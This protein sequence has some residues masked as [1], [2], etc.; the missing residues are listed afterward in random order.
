MIFQT[1]VRV[2]IHEFLKERGISQSRIA[3][4]LDIERSTLHN[5]LK[6]RRPLSPER[7]KE[8][9]DFLNTDFKLNENSL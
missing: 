2:E 3:A 9:N 7:L 5:I 4:L 8:I 1:D 6:C